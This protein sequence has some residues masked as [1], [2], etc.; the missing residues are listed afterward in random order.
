[1]GQC[2]QGRCLWGIFRGQLKKGFYYV[3][4]FIK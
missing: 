4:G 3:M 1:V 2:G